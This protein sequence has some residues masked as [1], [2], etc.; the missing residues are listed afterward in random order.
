MLGKGLESLIPKK[1]ESSEQ[2]SERTGRPSAPAT[3]G[4][5]DSR[6]DDSNLAPP[7]GASFGDQARRGSETF[8]TTAAQ[9][10]KKNGTTEAIFQIEVEKIKPNPLQPR[11][12]FDENSLKEL[13]ASI[14]EFGILQPILV[15]KI[16]KEVENGTEVEYQLIAGERRFRAAQMLG[17]KTVPAIV[18]KPAKKMDEL[19][20]AITENLQRS[21]LSPI[22]TAR[23]YAK[24]QDEFNMTQRE[25]AQRLGKSRETVANT[26]RLLNLPSE[27]Q[28]ALAKNLINESQARLLLVV[29]DLSQQQN[30]FKQLIE[31]NL[32]VR[33]LRQ[34][35]GKTNAKPKMESEKTE[36]VAD[37]EIAGL[38]ERLAE[39]LGAQV[40][41]NPPANSEKGG[42][43]IITFY[44]PEEIEGII[45][46]LSPNG[47]TEG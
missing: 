4:G 8:S 33:E 10:K 31:N 30:L 6:P 20:I 39:L 21:D 28:D 16:E 34:K 17:W 26:L 19:E 41:I 29:E 44:S 12:D 9:N 23:A 1:K 13:A 5:L 43:I 46:K 11:R 25:I 18:K 24:L 38:E 42:K 32:S 45:K 36:I 2:L 3:E 27:I 14:Q 7:N 15:S 47:K 22:E 35:I 40:N 37:P